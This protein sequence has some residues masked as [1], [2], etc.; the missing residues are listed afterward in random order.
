[1]EGNAALRKVTV[2]NYTEFSTI[3]SQHLHNVKELPPPP[4]AFYEVGSRPK[5]I[6]ISYCGFNYQDKK[7]LI[8]VDLNDT[9]QPLITLDL[10]SKTT[11]KSKS[12]TGASQKDLSMNYSLN[13][14]CPCGCLS[15]T[16]L[17]RAQQIHSR[18]QK[19]VCVY[20]YRKEYSP[21][22]AGE[23]KVSKLL[24]S[25]H[26]SEQQPYSKHTYQWWYPLSL[27][28]VQRQ[29][30]IYEIT[31]YTVSTIYL[32]VLEVDAPQLKA[33]TTTTTDQGMERYP[34]YNDDT[35]HIQETIID[36]VGSFPGILN[37][38]DASISAEHLSV[39]KKWAKVYSHDSTEFIY[40][41]MLTNKPHSDAATERDIFTPLGDSTLR[42]ESRFESGNLL[43]AT[44][45]PLCTETEVPEISTVP[46][47]SEYISNASGIV[48]KYHATDQNYF[49]M[50]RPDTN[51]TG[52]TQW[53]YFAV[54][55]TIPGIQYNFFIANFTKTS[56]QY[57]EGMTPVVFSETEYMLSG[58]GW[59]RGGFDV[60][61][62][63]NGKY[64]GAGPS[65]MP[66]KDKKAKDSD[67]DDSQDDSQVPIQSQLSTTSK[68][69]LKP[70]TSTN[71][72]IKPVSCL[73][74]SY[75]TLS[76]SYVFKYAGDIVYFAHTYPYTYRHEQIW[77]NSLIQKNI[78]QRRS[79]N[80]RLTTALTKALMLDGVSD[81]SSQNNVVEGEVLLPEKAYMLEFAK[82]YCVYTSLKVNFLQKL[83]VFR[84][85]PNYQ[86]VAKLLA[87]EDYSNADIP[88]LSH[89]VITKSIGGN[90]VDMLTI[91]SSSSSIEELRNKK[92]IV[93]SA[94]IHPGEAQSSYVCQGFVDYLLSDAPV[95]SFLRKNYIFK[96]FPIINPDGVILGN[97]R[98]NLAGADLNRRC[99]QPSMALHT[100]I[101]GFK[102][103][104]H[105]LA[106]VPSTNV[107]RSTNLCEQQ[108]PDSVD[109]STSIDSLNSKDGIEKSKEKVSCHTPSGRNEDLTL[110]DLVA[111]DYTAIKPPR[112]SKSKSN[113]SVRP[114]TCKPSVKKL[115]N[116]SGISSS[117]FEFK[118]AIVSNKT[119]LANIDL[120]GHS[121]KT[122]VFGYA[123]YGDSDNHLYFKALNR[124]SPYFSIKDCRYA[125][126][127]QKECTQRAVSYNNLHIPY[128][129]CIETTFGGVTK[130]GSPKFGLQMC[131]KDFL[132]VG[133]DLA[134][135][136]LYLEGEQLTS[137]HEFAD[138][139][140][141]EMY[142]ILYNSEA[143]QF[144]HQWFNLQSL[145]VSKASS[146]RTLVLD[147][148]EVY[149]KL[150]E[151]VRE[152]EHQDT[153][154]EVSEGDL[155]N[156]EAGTTTTS[157]FKQGSSKGK[158]TVCFNL[159]VDIASEPHPCTSS[160]KQKGRQKD[161]TYVIPP[162]GSTISFPCIYTE[163]NLNQDIYIIEQVKAIT[164]LLPSPS[165]LC[166]STSKLQKPDQDGHSSDD[167]IQVEVINP[168]K[169]KPQRKRLSSSSGAGL[170]S[171][172]KL[173]VSPEGMEQLAKEII[174][175]QTDEVQLERALE[176][177]I[178][179]RE[180]TERPNVG[181]SVKKCGKLIYKSLPLRPEVADAPT[182]E[183]VSE[184]MNNADQKSSEAESQSKGRPKT[185][186]KQ[187]SAVRD[188]SN[189]RNHRDK[190]NQGATTGDPS[191]KQGGKALDGISGATISEN[192]FPVDGFK[193]SWGGG[194]EKSA[195]KSPQADIF[196]RLA[197]NTYKI[198]P[199]KR[200]YMQETM[201][202]SRLA[203][204]SIVT[205]TVDNLPIDHAA[206]NIANRLQKG[207]TSS[208]VWDDSQSQRTGTIPTSQSFAYSSSK[209]NFSVMKEQAFGENV[210]NTDNTDTGPFIAPRRPSSSQRAVVSSA[211]WGPGAQRPTRARLVSVPQVTTRTRTA[212]RSSVQTQSGSKGSGAGSG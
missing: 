123:C 166:T 149:E 4:D 8:H 200:E 143:Q 195:K 172:S 22:N 141:V 187:D 206:A 209:N 173:S 19:A 11:A 144:V 112:Q 177:E 5:D 13:L 23:N 136:M 69:A 16:N 18:L 56:S 28:H 163:Q 152:Q 192:G 164:S 170:G 101:Y 46:Y 80:N 15:V 189:K 58:R 188:T 202:T 210:D 36:A 14:N 98:C 90:D 60:A 128:S 74:G 45:L 165:T 120:H 32:S 118:P 131:Q 92:I 130:P 66:N 113:T 30:Q 137:L 59:E 199:E 148:Y 161:I 100:C 10:K 169:P 89:K 122:N 50:L 17:T 183:H 153:L 43:Q 65:T 211:G 185:G 178:A 25:S 110:N 106:S 87:S 68:I 197:K 3:I 91:T 203:T 85:S 175:A 140:L 156:E 24:Q 181:L 52:N 40:S 57:S 31:H 29:S 9:S 49:L 64:L 180:Q 104:L 159:D 190:N 125:I 71:T 204:Y 81:H 21:N 205:H 82:A 105:S 75:Y 108:H 193:T 150:C 171:G 168:N 93:V 179:V 126:G 158:K 135:S 42:F 63:S 115:D 61:Y 39:R 76:F 208:R 116:M 109:S 94:R 174:A 132:D 184:Q 44:R 62:Y 102:K 201:R 53:Y 129:Y 47:K 1:M 124:L 78:L 107:I 162:I 12:K 114:S 67:Y 88:I 198:L 48:A 207:L 127:K 97:Y 167:D 73:L 146:T 96:I 34:N 145:L 26:S 111:I 33:L 138:E 51:S 186:I 103:V 6:I 154:H 54:G 7:P 176:N 117:S 212:G 157:A 99:I 41:N 27:S 2:K 139:F 160:L 55:N 38:T 86:T 70:D 83:A 182:T 37:L 77:I 147:D 79:I 35:S 134:Q 121:R 151:W 196:S 119:I 133:K 20:H 95:A 142:S 84:S 72:E 155:L 191:V 194:S